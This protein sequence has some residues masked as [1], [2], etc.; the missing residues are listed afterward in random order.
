MALFGRKKSKA[1]Q[2]TAG[3]G[4]AD[5]AADTPRADDGASAAMTDGDASSSSSDAGGVSSDDELLEALPEDYGTQAEKAR[6]KMPKVVIVKQYCTH[7]AGSD[8]ER[9]TMCCPNDAITLEPGKPP[10]VD[11]EMCT[12]CGICFGVCDAFA[13]TRLTMHD[14]H[15]RIQRIATSGRRAYLTCKENVFPGLV[16][17]TN[18]VVLPCLSMISPDFFTLLLSENIRLTISCDLK[19]CEDCW[20]AGDLGGELFPRAIEIA[21]ERTGEKVLFTMR[22]PEQQ[23]IIDKVTDVDPLGRREAFTGFAGD[24]AEIASGKRRLR[25]STVLQDYYLKKEQQ[26]AA[27]LVNLADE[28]PF[29][30][31]KPAGHVR[32]VL[33]PQQKM[34]LEAVQRRPDIA[35]SIPVLVSCTDEEAC[36]NALACADACPT[37]ARGTDADGKISLDARLCVGCGICVDACEH[38]ACSVEEATAQIYV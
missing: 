32:K 15:T 13:S 16:P 36:C 18:V 24:F 19:Y 17:D 34:I 25:N 4:K 23:T 31:F 29:E 21:E 22:I 35:E 20:R 10:V 12:G 28:S 14:L 5:G 26:R 6:K 2:A 7:A 9:C 30:N 1:N 27:A 11:R 37:G 38:G 3:M 33:F 8:C